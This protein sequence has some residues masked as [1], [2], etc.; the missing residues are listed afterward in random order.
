[1]L[2]PVDPLPYLGEIAMSQ[3]MKRTHLVAISTGLKLTVGDSQELST[4]ETW[5]RKYHG[6]HAG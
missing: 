2:Q 4:C 1:M 5:A 3:L 6:L